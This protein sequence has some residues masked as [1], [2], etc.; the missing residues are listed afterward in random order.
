M[1]WKH[2]FDFCVDNELEGP[3]NNSSRE[4]SVETIATTQVGD[5]GGMA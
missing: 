3:R 4:I 5:N 2:F 1:F